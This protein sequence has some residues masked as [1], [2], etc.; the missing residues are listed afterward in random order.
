MVNKIIAQNLLAVG[1]PNTLEPSNLFESNGLRPDGVSLVPYK[2]GKSVT[3]DFTC[4]H[5]LCLSHLPRDNINES[6]ESKKVEK[7][8]SLA[9][10]YIFIPISIDTFGRYGP[11]AE[12][13]LSEVGGRLSEKF[14]D[15]RRA[16]FFKQNIAI[17]IQRGNAKSLLL[18][19]ITIIIIIIIIIIV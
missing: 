12:K 4:P 2:K 1:L 6:A 11:Q 19:I 16:T 5:P 7:Y 9:E 18:I 15:P 8:T 10:N 14:N 3:W 17:A 13:F